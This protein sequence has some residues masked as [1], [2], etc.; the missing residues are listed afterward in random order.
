MECLRVLAGNHNRDV[1]GCVAMMPN[2]RRAVSAGD[3]GEE[4]ALRVWDT[5]TGEC[6]CVMQGHTSWIWSVS[7]TADGGRAVSG[8]AD[9]TVRLWDLNTGA[10]LRVLEGHT[11]GVWSIKV[12]PDGRRSV[13]R[14]MDNSMRV[15]DL[16]TGACLIAARIPALSTDIAFSSAL[17]RA[18]AGKSTGEVIQ[19]DLPGI[20]P[21][22]PAEV[23]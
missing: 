4:Y 3:M 9:N 10:C 1:Y 22:A 11:K 18:I 15:W 8:S 6:L 23:P 2:G 13:S 14:S 12:T 5:E 7:I 16:E 17:N 20:T 21:I 19:F